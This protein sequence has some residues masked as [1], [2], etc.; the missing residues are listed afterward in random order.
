MQEILVEAVLE[1]LMEV[2]AV[3]ETL[4]EGEA[5]PETLMGVAAQEILEVGEERSS[6]C[7]P[8]QYTWCR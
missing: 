6:G 3:P 7:G 2:E 5:V 1:T 4:M 8:V